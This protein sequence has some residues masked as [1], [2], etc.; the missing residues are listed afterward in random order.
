MKKIGLFMLLLTLFACRGEEEMRGKRI[1]LLAHSTGA[2]LY[3]QGDV[4]GWFDR[5]NRDHG[6]NYQIERRYF[7]K[8]R[9]Y[10]WENYPYDYW[11]IWV[12]KRGYKFEPSL[13]RLTKKYDLIIMKHCFPGSVMVADPENPTVEEKTKALAVYKLQ[14][15]ELKKAMHSHGD[16]QFLVWTQAVMREEDISVIEGERTREFVEWVKNEWDEPG[17]N[18][19]IWDFYGYETTSADG[20]D[21]SLFLRPEYNDN[22]PHPNE[23]FNK[24]TAP[25]L[26]EKIIQILER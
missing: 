22:D 17:D 1:V 24:A 20:T 10:G 21:Q 12:D 18:I 9:F 23:A 14:Y 7:P 4:S 11:K 5:Y 2:Q 13:E 19:D 6:T 15:E 16:T 25:H 3:S 26:C 8:A